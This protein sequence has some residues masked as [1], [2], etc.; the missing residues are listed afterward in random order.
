MTRVIKIYVFIIILVSK[1]T[2]KSYKMEEVYSKTKNRQL[3]LR[4]VH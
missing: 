3:M 2:L 1:I 4:L